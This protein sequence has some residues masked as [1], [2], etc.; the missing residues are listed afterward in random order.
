MR[1][2]AIKQTSLFRVKVTNSSCGGEFCTNNKSSLLCYLHVKSFINLCM[3]DTLKYSLVTNRW[4]QLP[5]K[6]YTL[7][8]AF[9]KNIVATAKY[10]IEISHVP[11]KMIPLADTLSRNFLPDT[12]PEICDGMNVQVYSL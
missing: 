5:R 10:N 11:G 7:H 2:I 6:S 4:Y 9:G 3:D 1:I 12:Y 8:P